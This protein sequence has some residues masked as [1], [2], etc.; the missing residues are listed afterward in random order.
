MGIAASADFTGFLTAVQGT[1]ETGFLPK[2]ASGGSSTA[3]WADYC[4]IAA[5]SVLDFGGYWRD[6]DNVGAFGF[7]LNS[8]PSKVWTFVGGRLMYVKP[9]Q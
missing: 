4:Y 3:Y 9:R 5:S 6:G 8:S 1:T 7:G 2:T